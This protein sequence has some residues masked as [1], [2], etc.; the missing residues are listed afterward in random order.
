MWHHNAAHYADHAY[1]TSHAGMGWFGHTVI[2]SI[3]HGLVYGAIFRLFRG[4]SIETVLVIAI[5]GIS[6]L[7]AL[8][9]LSSRGD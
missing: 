8:Y 3:I 6:L 4:M 5:V 7:G 1:A 2:S 9:W